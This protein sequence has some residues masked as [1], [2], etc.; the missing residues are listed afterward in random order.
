M[1]RVTPEKIIKLFPKEVFV[2]GCNLAGRHGKGASKTAYQFGAVY[3]KIGFQGQT[4][5]IPTKDENIQTLPISEIKKYVDQFITF[6]INNP[7]LKCLV[8][9]IG[10]GL[11]GHEVKNI[12]PLFKKAILVNNIYL[13]ES[14][15][16]Y[17]ET[18]EDWNF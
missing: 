14:F 1:K 13:P 12:A 10:T 18:I 11:A 2:Y 15:W 8:T 7:K 5:G 4:Y 16:D 3:G 17:L 9:A 6:A